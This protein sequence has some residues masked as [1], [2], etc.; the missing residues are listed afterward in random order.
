M[1]RLVLKTFPTRS[2]KDDLLDTGSHQYSR[3]EV[4]EGWC[5]FRGENF[6][7]AAARLF[8]PEEDHEKEADV[9]MNVEDRVE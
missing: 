7:A 3:K 4:V 6:L 9:E 1:M 8:E 5:V 2:C